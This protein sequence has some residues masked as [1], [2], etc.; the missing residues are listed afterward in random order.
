MYV[1]TVYILVLFKNVTLLYLYFWTVPPLPMQSTQFAYGTNSLGGT[2][3]VAQKKTLFYININMSIYR[4]KY[5]AF[6]G[7]TQAKH[8]WCAIP[9]S[10]PT[11]TL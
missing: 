8:M 4:N 1:C 9:A 6:Y 7:K 11:Y 3:P 10:V 5:T 2:I